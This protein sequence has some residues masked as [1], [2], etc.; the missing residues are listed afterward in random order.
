MSTLWYECLAGENKGRVYEVDFSTD[1][2]Q[3]FASVYSSEKVGAG[4]VSPK[5]Y[6]DS[7]CKKGNFRLL[8]HSPFV[9]GII[10]EAE[11]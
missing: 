8:P 2:F 10:F 7:A 3:A 11:E 6:W 9:V 4:S 1:T 5:V